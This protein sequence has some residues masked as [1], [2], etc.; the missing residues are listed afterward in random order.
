LDAEPSV[1]GTATL[2]VLCGHWRYAHINAVRGDTLNPGLP[3]MS[4]TV[5]EDGVRRAMKRMEEDTVRILFPFLGSMNSS[6]L[7]H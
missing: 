7:F 3:G 4:T 5:S 2:S 1:L 6:P